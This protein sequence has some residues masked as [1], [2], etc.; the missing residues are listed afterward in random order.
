MRSPMFP[1]RVVAALAALV[2]SLEV[3]ADST[4]DLAA[5]FCASVKLVR[6]SI[7]VVA[8]LLALARMLSPSRPFV[9]FVSLVAASATVLLSLVSVVPSIISFAAV[10]ASSRVA[11]FV[12]SL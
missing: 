7:T 9:A 12:A 5:D 1:S 10:K 8:A 4:A 6:A 2:A 11:L 3:V